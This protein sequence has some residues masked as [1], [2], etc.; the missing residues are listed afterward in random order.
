MSNLTLDLLTQPYD[1]ELFEYD[2]KEQIYVPKVTAINDYAYVNLLRDWT[3][4]ENAQSYLFL[5]SRVVNETIL[6][7]KDAKYQTIMKYYLAHSKKARIELFKI[8]SDSVWYNRRD[9]GFMMAYNSGANLNQGKLIEFGIDKALSPI[10]KQ[11]VMNSY[12]GT[13]YLPYDINTKVRLDDFDAVLSYLVTNGYITQEQSDEISLLTE[14]KISDLPYDMSY[15]ITDE[16][17]GKYLFTDLH[18][19]KKA[20]AKMRM[21]DPVNGTW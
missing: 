2:Y 14:P 7:M 13:R 10:A 12:L 8:Y 20:I 17:D 5:L 16:P 4:E 19:L 15:R 3:T 1:D 11:I 18:T 9:G 21:Y 6:S